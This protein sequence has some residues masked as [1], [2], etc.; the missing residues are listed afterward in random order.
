MNDEPRPVPSADEEA[1]WRRRFGMFALLR[2]SGLVLII[3]GIAIA[4]TP[5]LRPGGWPVPGALMAIAGL[6]VGTLLPHRL[7]RGWRKS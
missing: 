1:L 2:V 6:I 3:V 7:R 4:F 5:F